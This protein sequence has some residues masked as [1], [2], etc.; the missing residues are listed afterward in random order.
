MA[1]RLHI[2]KLT[3]LATMVAIGFPAF[4]MESES[5]ESLLAVSCT[6][7]V[8][9][10]RPHSGPWSGRTAAP[11]KTTFEVR[12]DELT[13]IVLEPRIAY[14]VFPINYVS[15]T[16]ISVSVED[17]LGWTWLVSFDR[18]TGEF[19]LI[20]S[21]GNAFTGQGYVAQARIKAQCWYKGALL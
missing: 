21:K 20:S 4:G 6:G 10:F 18:L 17:E 8:I 11:Q 15:E 12:R 3:L 16:G 19:L 14:N 5:S 7:E 1:K 9:V 2:A 13:L